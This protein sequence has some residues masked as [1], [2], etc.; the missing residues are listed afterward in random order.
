MS[1][2]NLAPACAMATA[3]ILFSV[4]RNRAVQIPPDFV[5]LTSAVVVSPA[6][7][8]SREKRAVAMLVEEVEKRSQVRWRTSE[9]WPS[10]STAVIV[11]GTPGSLSRLAAAPPLK[12][13]RGPL[14]A[15]GF[16]IRLEKTR[17]A[18]SVFVIGNDS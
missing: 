6:D 3:L 9:S 8:S 14:G 18:P 1:F 7:L 12:P 17:T 15:E 2:G 13:D 16:R 4:D 5:D 11:L 10:D